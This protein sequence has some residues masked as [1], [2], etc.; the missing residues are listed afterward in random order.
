[1]IGRYARGSFVSLDK[2]YKAH[3]ATYGAI[4]KA[5]DI[6]FVPIAM[7]SLGR[8][9]KE[10]ATALK[11]LFK[12]SNPSPSFSSTCSLAVSSKSLPTFSPSSRSCDNT[13][14]SRRRRGVLYECTNPTLLVK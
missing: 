1:M 10:S 2:A 8:M 13:R 12:T 3:A 7:D 6:T 4:C 5:R 9:H 11:K 14:T